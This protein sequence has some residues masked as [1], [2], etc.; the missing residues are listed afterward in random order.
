MKKQVI[1]SSCLTML[2]LLPL[3]CA[4]TNPDGTDFSDDRSIPP[5]W[6]ISPP[7]SDEYIYAVG[8]SGKTHKPSKSREQALTRAVKL[9]AAQ[10]EIYIRNEM[11]L[12]QDMNRVISSDSLTES[13]ITGKIKGFTIV[14]ERQCF[15][16]DVP[17]NLQG[18]TYILIRIP[19]SEL[20][21]H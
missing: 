8:W 6:A 14:A 11:V 4:S 15:G 21:L 2:F 19:K 18:S 7:Q 13:A 9:L 10:A 12:W 20:R 17:P 16:K 5:G 1:L 3:A